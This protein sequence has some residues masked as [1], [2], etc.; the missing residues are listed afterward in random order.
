MICFVE[1]QDVT[2]HDARNA[3]IVEITMK[4]VVHTKK[5]LHGNVQRIVEQWML[6]QE[7]GSKRL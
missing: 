6:R 7:P 2:I 4:N 5:I 3:S 1:M